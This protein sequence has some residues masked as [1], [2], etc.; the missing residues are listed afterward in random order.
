M[1]RLEGVTAMITLAGF[2]LHPAQLRAYQGDLYAP[3]FIVLG[4]WYH[5]YHLQLKGG[6]TEAGE[7]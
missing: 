1:D 2:I 6:V 7:S 4:D 3:S 5:L